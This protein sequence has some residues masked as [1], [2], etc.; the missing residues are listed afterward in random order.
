MIADTCGCTPGSG[1]LDKVG[2]GNLTLS[3]VN[4]YTGTTSVNGGKLTVDG[5]IVSSSGTTVNSGG[6]LSVNGSAGNVIVNAGGTLGGNGVV[7]N[8][9]IGDG[10]ALAPGNSVGLLTVQGNLVFTAAATYMVEISP[11]GA[12][13]TNVTGTA[14]FGG[15]TVNAIFA[16]GTYVTKQYTILSTAGGVRRQ[17][18]RAAEHQSAE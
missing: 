5:S 15:A 17:P 7:A 6:T 18:V 12:D 1:S 4:T 16:A 13:R 10:G 11:A 2:T 3:G 14:S 8:A 9:T